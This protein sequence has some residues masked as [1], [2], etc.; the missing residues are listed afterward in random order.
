MDFMNFIDPPLNIIYNENTIHSKWFYLS[1]Q[2]FIFF[3]HLLFNSNK[4]LPINE[5]KVHL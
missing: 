2:C 5:I 3:Y 1:H 4:Y